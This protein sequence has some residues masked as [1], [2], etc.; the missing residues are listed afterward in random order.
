MNTVECS[1]TAF[2]MK[3][4]AK[5]CRTPNNKL[6]LVYVVVVVYYFVYQNPKSLH[7]VP[8]CFKDVDAFKIEW[9]GS[10]GYTF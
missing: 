1:S 2:E 9:S 5:I 4:V 6:H 7:C 10:S 3:C 8:I